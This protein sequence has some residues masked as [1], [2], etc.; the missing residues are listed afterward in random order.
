MEILG[1]YKA[2]LNICWIWFSGSS[3]NCIVTKYFAS[4]F[5]IAPPSAEFHFGEAFRPSH[6]P[7]ATSTGFLFPSTKQ[8][9]SEP[10]PFTFHSASVT[11]CCFLFLHVSA[12]KTVETPHFCPKLASPI[13]LPPYDNVGHNAL[14]TLLTLLTQSLCRLLTR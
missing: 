13:G 4:C 5:L 7:K 12:P 9:H 14:S 2:L 10:Y 11:F 1:C 3:P 8:N 6:M